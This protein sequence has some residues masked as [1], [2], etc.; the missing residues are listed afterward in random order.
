MATTDHAADPITDSVQSVTNQ[1]LTEE[2]QIEHDKEIIN[3]KV[4]EIL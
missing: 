4:K 1:V 3:Q 2:E